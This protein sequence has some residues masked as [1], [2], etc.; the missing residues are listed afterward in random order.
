MTP[1]FPR[2]AESWPKSFVLGHAAS[3]RQNQ[4]SYTRYLFL[5]Y[6]ILSL[7]TRWESERLKRGPRVS[8]GAWRK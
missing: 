3:T 6:A 1:V 7:S 5:R 8:D 2:G 4:D